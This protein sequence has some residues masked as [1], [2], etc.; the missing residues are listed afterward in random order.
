[1]KRDV[2]VVLLDDRANYLSL[3][4]GEGGG[5]GGGSKI[6]RLLVGLHGPMALGHPVPRLP[7]SPFGDEG[8]S[9]F[10][11]ACVFGVLIAQTSLIF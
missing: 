8:R 2:S 1:M 9:R 11:G 4:L 6:S 10:D 5:W 3:L 7:P